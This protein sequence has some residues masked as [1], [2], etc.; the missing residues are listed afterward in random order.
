MAVL[1]S[2]AI[3]NIGISTN[4]TIYTVPAATTTVVIGA[5]LA[6]KLSTYITLDIILVKSGVEYFILKGVYLAPGAGY[7]WSG[8]EQ[9]IVMNTGDSFIVRSSADVSADAIIS[10][11]EL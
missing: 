1:K 4:N 8:A 5:N 10:I 3:A 2:V 11:T 6:N 7:V 9:K